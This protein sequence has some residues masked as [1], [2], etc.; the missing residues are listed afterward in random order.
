LALAEYAYSPSVHRS[1]KLT[2]F[3]LHLGSA[4]LLPLDA[5]AAIQR[6]LANESVKTLQGREFV[7][8]L[9]SI[10]GVATEEFRYAPHKQT[11]EGNKSRRPID[12]VITAGAEVFFDTKDLPIPYA[13]VIPT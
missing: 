13:N 9:Q 8:Q 2:A 5:I 6:R 11:A 7:E 10:F 4:P 3:E 1:Q 12:P